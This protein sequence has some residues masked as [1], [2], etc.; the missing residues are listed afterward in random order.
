MQTIALCM[1]LDWMDGEQDAECKAVALSAGLGV[2]LA[3]LG[4]V[5]QTLFTNGKTGLD[6]TSDELGQMVTELLVSAGESVVACEPTER[7][8]RIIEH[9]GQRRDTVRQAALQET[10]P[11]R[12]MN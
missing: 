3:K 2:R 1:L 12:L 8:A 4:A 6:L 7:Q 11:R 9:I 5:R 10:T